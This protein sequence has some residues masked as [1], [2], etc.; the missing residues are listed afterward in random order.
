MSEGKSEKKKSFIGSLKATFKKVTSRKY[1]KNDLKKLWAVA[2]DTGSEISEKP[3]RETG[4]LLTAAVVPGA[5]VAWV[6]YRLKRYQDRKA[7]NDNKKCAAPEA[8]AACEKKPEAKK[9]CA[10]GC[11]PGQ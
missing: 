2:K 4:L 10:K 3:L 11:K 7:A 1:T 8:N 6:V 5:G 9:S